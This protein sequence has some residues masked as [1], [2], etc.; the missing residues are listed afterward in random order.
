MNIKMESGKENC[1]VFGDDFYATCFSLETR[2]NSIE[3]YVH[4]LE[5]KLR[6]VDALEREN[7]TQI[8]KYYSTVF[9]SENTKELK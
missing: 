2:N 4:E 9:H 1:D 8:L 3:E 5:T 6:K 7:G